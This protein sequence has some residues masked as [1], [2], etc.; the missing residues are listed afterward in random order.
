MLKFK[1]QQRR[2][3][4]AVATGAQGRAGRCGGIKAMAES[5]P[6]PPVATVQPASDLAVLIYT[7]GTTGIA[8]GAML[9]HANLCAN[10]RQAWAWLTTIEEGEDA[11]SSRRCR[12]STP[13]GCSRWSSRS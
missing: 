2:C 13:T 7:G 6:M 11:V 3:G 1:K 8:K 5:G 9:S 4:Q 10:A 12:S